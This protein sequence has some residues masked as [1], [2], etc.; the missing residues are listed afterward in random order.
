MI[1]I[2]FKI[3]R[4]AWGEKGVELAKICARV[5]LKTGVKIIPVVSALEYGKIRNSF[6]GEM[7]LEHADWQKEGA[8]SGAISMEQAKVAGV[9]G[10][11]IN[12]SEKKLKLGTI[13][14][15]VAAKPEG[16]KLLTICQ[17]INQITKWGAGLKTDYLAWE[18]MELIGNPEVSVMDKYEEQVKK[19][20]LSIK[21]PLIIGSGIH[22]GEDVR[23]AIG[24]GAAGV[25]VASDVVKAGDPEKELTELAE[26]F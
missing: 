9:A 20:A 21:V 12:H 11:L 13:K 18:P 24:A 3:Y 1:F 4:E 23:R 7:F 10:S 14:K 8:Y 26:A 19:L 25:L 15:T 17:N 16:F 2:N 5:E 22:R 6:G